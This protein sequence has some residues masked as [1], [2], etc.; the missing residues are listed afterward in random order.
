MLLLAALSLVVPV[1]ADGAMQ[2]IASHWQ[3][4]TLADHGKFMDSWIRCM[5]ARVELGGCCRPGLMFRRLDLPSVL[6]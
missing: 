5:P 4:F 6:P 3:L 2:T 1:L